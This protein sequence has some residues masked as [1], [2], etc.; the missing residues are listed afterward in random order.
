M[1][2]RGETAAAVRP[3]FSQRRTRSCDC[4]ADPTGRRA[5]LSGRRR[6]HQGAE[7]GNRASAG[8]RP[9][10]QHQC[11]TRARR[12]S[13]AT[14]WRASIRP[15]TRPH[16]DQ[17]VAKK[18]QD[19]AQLANARIDLERYTRLAATNSIA[20]QQVDTQNATVAQ[21][22]A[23]IKLDQA[24]IDNAQ[25]RARLH[26]DHRADRGPH[27]HPAWSMQGNIVPRAP[28]ST[29]IVVITQFQPI[30]VLFSL[31]QQQT[32]RSQ[33]RVRRRPAAGRRLRP[34]QQD[35]RST[36]ACSRWSTTRSTRPPGTVRLKA[37]FPNADLQ[38]WPGQFVNVRL[39]I[40]TLKQ[41]VVV[42]TAAVQRGP[43]GTFVYVVQP[44]NTVAVRPVEVA[45]QDDMQAVIARGL[46]ADERVVTTGF[47]RLTEGQRGDRRPMPRRRRRRRARARPKRRRRRRGAAADRPRAAISRQRSEP[48]RDERLR[49]LHPAADRDLAARRRDHA[50]RLLGY[51]WLPVSSLPQVDFPDHPGHDPAARR[52]SGHHGGAGDGAARTPVRPDPG[53]RDDDLVEFVRHQPDHAAVRSRPRHR[54]CRAGRAGG[55]Q[56]R[57]LDAAAQPALSA[58]L[59]EGEPGRRADPDAGADLADH[60]AARAQ[61]PRRHADGAAPAEVSGRRPR[62]GAGR[63]PAGGA[64]PG[65]SGAACRL[66]HRARGPA[67][68]DRRRQC[69]RPQGLAR[70]RAPVLHHL[71]QRPAH[72]RR[73]LSRRWSS[74][75]A[76]TRRCCS[77]DVAQIV[78]GLENDKV[79]AW[80]KGMPAVVIDIQRQPGANVIETVERIKQRAAA[81]AARHAGRR[82]R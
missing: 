37:E 56:C 53:A 1:A 49:A 73:G 35:G 54:R 51:S 19:E 75:T 64:H 26:H 15:P 41:V 43:N 67:P 27:R 59:L 8:R 16:Y 5:G 11:S 61:R 3:W 2:T 34:R 10:H 66:R 7:H 32:R 45:Q 42:P 29:G 31:P 78:D 36:A 47:A 76:T 22:E 33:P 25:S 30:S 68:G 13:A 69:R 39:L 46:E 70:R 40:D 48:R 74:P 82:R 77:S 24:A 81:A 4:S 65:R 12:S 55:D 58:D 52:Q 62:L 14:C 18:A 71:G 63:H 50:G 44:D 57:R 72:R 79:G 23:Q 28:N 17:A 20:K 80:Y 38:L 60:P 21:L 9:P 6:H